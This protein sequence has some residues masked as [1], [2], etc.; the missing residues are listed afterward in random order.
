MKKTFFVLITVFLFSGGNIWA[1]GV[2]ID[3]SGNLTTGSGNLNGTLEVDGQTDSDAVIGITGGNGSAI[4]GE[5]PDSGGHAGYFQGNAEVTG[6][7]TVVSDLTVNGNLN[8]AAGTITGTLANELDPTVNALG[9]VTLSC[10][11]N[12][13]AKWNGSTWVCAD[14]IETTLSEAEVDA[15]VG[16]NGYLTAETDPTVNLLAKAPLHPS[17]AINQVPKWS[18]GSWSCQN[19]ADTDTTYSAGAGLDLNG[20]TFSLQSPFALDNYSASST[21]AIDGANWGTGAGIHGITFG[22]GPAGFFQ[23]GGAGPAGYFESAGGLGDGLRVVGYT[24]LD[25]TAGAPPSTDCNSASHRGRM[26]VDNV[27]GLL[28]ICVDTGWVSK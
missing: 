9:K 10:S 12:Q 26:K 27:A 20:T 19:D 18:G 28:Y 14:D 25:L 4:Y 5:N 8:V 23:S 3:S 6:D 22:A 16:N 24:R 13:V 2:S 11:N 7:L 21:Y 1:Q 15:F 17:C